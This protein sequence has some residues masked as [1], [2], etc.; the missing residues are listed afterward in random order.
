[1]ISI[2]CITVSFTQ[3]IGPV[4]RYSCTPIV[5]DEVVASDCG[6]DETFIAA[7]T[8]CNCCA[9]CEPISENCECLYTY[10]YYPVSTDIVPSV[11]WYWIFP[12]MYLKCM[13]WYLESKIRIPLYHQWWAGKEHMKSYSNACSFELTLR[14][15][16]PS[17]I[18]ALSHRFLARILCYEI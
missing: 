5:C 10:I 7:H 18:R 11:H 8:R 17:F 12:H 4:C 15:Y 1:M 3:I 14:I 16:K 13:I 9:Y 6:S 2:V